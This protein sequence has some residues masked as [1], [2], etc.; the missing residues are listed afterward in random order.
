MATIAL[1][2]SPKELSCRIVMFLTATTRRHISLIV[3]ETSVT[4]PV[5]LALSLDNSVQRPLAKSDSV[6]AVNQPENSGVV[7]AITMPPAAAPASIQALVP[8]DIDAY[9]DLIVANGVLP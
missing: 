6:I 8:D 9:H 3:F 4:V 2:I 1:I 7:S 5:T